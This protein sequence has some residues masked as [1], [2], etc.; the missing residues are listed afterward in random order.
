[1]ILLK[2]AILKNPSLK[3]KITIS[4]LL[5]L[6][7]STIIFAAVSL[8]IINNKF[9]SQVKEDGISLVDEI[10]AEIENNNL[11]IKQLEAVLGEKIT[12]TA[13]L[14]GQ[15]PAVSNEYLSEVAKEIDVQEI[16]VVNPSGVIVYSN[17]PDNIGYKYPAD[18]PAQPVIQGKETKLIE[19]IRKSSNNVDKNYYKYGIVS[20]KN[21]VIVQV[22][23][24]A[25]KVQE[26]NQIV[27]N[28]SLVD[29][30]GKKSN[31]TYALTI[32]PN[33]K[34]S[35]HSD[36]SRIGISLTD[37]G[38]KAAAQGGK[39]FSSL[40][41]YKGQEYVYDVLMPIKDNKS[42][43]GAF[44]IG[45][46]LKNEKSAIKF[47]IISFAIV[48]ALLLIVGGF[49]LKLIIGSMLNPLNKLALAAENV[50]QGDLTNNIEIK[51]HDEI[52]KL[53]LSF[54]N[55]ILNLKNIV[56][57]INEISV[58]LTSS[59][60]TLLISTEQAS[61]ASEEISSSTQEVANGAERQSNSTEEITS[62]M[63]IF[64][65]NI[66][67]IGEQVT[68]IVKSSE[69][70]SIL[71]SDGKKKMN[72]MI[73][74]IEVIKN[75]VNYSSEVIL[76][77]QRTSK[78]IGNIVEIIDGISDQTNLLALNASIEAARAGEAG[79]GFAVVAEEVRKLAEES[80]R[81]SNSIKQLIGTTQNKT[82][83]ALEAIEEGSR[84]SEKGQEIVKL[85]GEALNGILKS[86]D[87]TK[88]NLEKVNEMISDSRGNID[89][90]NENVQDI[91][92]ISI[93]TAANIEEVAAS[94][95]EQASMLEEIADSAQKLTNMASGL[96][97]SVKIFKL[98]NE[99][100][101]EK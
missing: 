51:N 41:K 42:T 101:I 95:E 57:K 28:Q 78:E 34:A 74:Q 52:G 29:R 84:E 62:S 71:A 45:L 88:E 1:M 87:N 11:M 79:K 7:I 37:E 55:M 49:I 14:V 89:K 99:E 82:N 6:I 39:M 25:N 100:N 81:S 73:N 32:D 17:L 85:V 16:N 33:L 76:E 24:V 44:D 77:L 10:T 48:S 26:L 65:D 23:I 15:N 5:V 66:S 43:V 75:S 92:G 56:T 96:E 9:E 46:S 61:A 60:Q 68:E 97:E 67:I 20:L 83:K 94:T 70:T 12:T 2:N 27:S 69:D 8:Y 19:Q 63:K 91:Q 35:A 30:L 53:G 90:M 3:F 47:I 54:N 64:V 58:S 59:S 31:I 40:Y 50:A 13:Y 72:N 21:G 18:H 93:N 22:G 36:K 80:M 86:F 98:N 4:S 38:S